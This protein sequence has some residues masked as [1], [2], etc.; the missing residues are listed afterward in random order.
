LRKRELAENHCNSLAQAR[1]PS[2]SEMD[3]LGWAKASNLSE[4]NEDPCSQCLIKLWLA[5]LSRNFMN[6]VHMIVMLG[7]KD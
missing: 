5:M 3:I 2:L 1:E 6:N 4:N 7:L